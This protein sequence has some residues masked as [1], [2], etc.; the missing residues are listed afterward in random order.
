[1]TGGLPLLYEAMLEVRAIPPPPSSAHILPQ[2][3]PP[4][5][6]VSAK[7]LAAA[8]FLVLLVCEE[9]CE[10]LPNSRGAAAAPPTTATS[11]AGRG[12]IEPR[13]LVFHCA[14]GEAPLLHLPPTYHPSRSHPVRLNVSC[15]GKDR[16][17]LLALLLTFVVHGDGPA[18]EARAVREYA[19]SAAL[20][21][22]RVRS[23]G[24]A[25]AD[26]A[27]TEA[28]AGGAEEEAG[29]RERPPAKASASASEAG[30]KSRGALNLAD[31]STLQG[32]PPAAVTDLLVRCATAL[33]FGPA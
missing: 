22:G 19:A 20:L 12:A 33:S 7:R 15:A 11:P 24:D 5:C 30:G 10:T 14:Q 4:C 17:G 27:E 2:P 18:T 1:M 6:Q 32:S 21:E 29:A 25:E 23:N 31:V 9:Y 16:T 26:R 3:L 28:E 8:L 13:S